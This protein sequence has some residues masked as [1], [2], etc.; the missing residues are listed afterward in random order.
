MS[1]TSVVCSCVWLGLSLAPGHLSS[2]SQP[3][4]SAWQTYVR[5]GD[6]GVGG[7]HR[8][9]CGRWSEPTLGPGCPGEARPGFLPVSVSGCAAEQRRGVALGEAAGA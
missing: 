5:G 2:H 4:L 9:G 7:L 3:S 6:S 1:H 8:R